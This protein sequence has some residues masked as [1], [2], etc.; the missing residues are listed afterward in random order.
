M[1]VRQI[2]SL[3]DKRQYE[4]ALA[5]C[6]KLLH[7]SEDCN[8][9]VLRVRSYVFALRGDYQRALQDREAVFE[10]GEGTIK[11]YYLG[12]DDAISAGN[13]TLAA[14]W[15]NEVLRLGEAQNEIWFESATYFLLAYVY[16]KLGQY[17]EAIINLD[18]AHA[19]ESDI[20][21]PL[22]GLG[23][24]D[25]NRLREEIKKNR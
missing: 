2:K 24:C 7:E 23:M 13:F 11:D 15:L 1:D 4:A 5:E 6:E 10:M 25:H 14:K 9:D 8:P 18:N 17:Q 16:M 20:A 19:I 3:A 22:P 21:M 12:A